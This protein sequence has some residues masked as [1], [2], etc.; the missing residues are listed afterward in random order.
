MKKYQTILFDLDGTLTD[1]GPGIMNAVTYAL[2]HYGIEV[3]DRASLHRFIGPPLVDSFQ[4]FYG[5]SPEKAREATATFREYYNVKGIFENEP[6]EGILPL[7][8]ELQAAG[9]KVIMATSKPEK[10]A[11]RVA[12]H[13]DFAKYFDVLAGAAMD[14]TR[15]TKS[16]VLAY[17]LAQA[18]ADPAA[19]VMVGDR[20]F[21]VEGAKAFGLDSIGVLY[22][23]GPREELEAAGADYI[24]P[25]VADLHRLLLD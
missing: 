21:D 16:E 7:L 14:E 10:M 8:A 11:L 18:D 15:T 3:E 5:F 2:H 20:K 19:T 12:E 25:T 22:G 6:Y 1:S 17:A 13:F 9:R 23:Y 24:A 4:E